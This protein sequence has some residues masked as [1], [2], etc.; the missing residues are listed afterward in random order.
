MRCEWTQS[1]SSNTNSPQR[2]AVSTMTTTLQSFCSRNSRTHHAVVAQPYLSHSFLDCK[3]VLFALHH[4]L[5]P[6]AAPADHSHRPQLF[7]RPDIQTSDCKMTATDQMRQMLDQLMGTS[8]NGELNSTRTHKHIHPWTVRTRAR[9]QGETPL[10]PWFNWFVFFF[11]SVCRRK[12]PV[13]PE[14]PRRQS[15]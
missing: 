8:R 15:M 3:V 10:L 12:R 5:L 14:V 2:S 13:R 9:V 1:R 11:V 4:V 7:D 6:V